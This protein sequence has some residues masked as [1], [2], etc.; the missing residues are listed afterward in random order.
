MVK[1]C[2]LSNRDSV[3]QLILFTKLWT[4]N[5][6]YYSPQS[7]VQL[8]PTHQDN[9]KISG[10]LGIS[11]Q[12]RAL[13]FTYAVYIMT[14]Y[15]F[16]FK[17]KCRIHRHITICNI[18]TMQRNL[19]VATTPIPCWQSTTAVRNS[20]HHATH[21]QMPISMSDETVHVIKG[22]AAPYITQHIYKCLF[23]CLMRLSA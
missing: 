12:L 10:I 20:I 23:L 13:L 6:C 3:T 7:N 14:L 9:F 18:Q 22:V 2:C 4:F 16:I 15:T 8:E 19:G 5:S 17:I 21:L 1:T 11:G